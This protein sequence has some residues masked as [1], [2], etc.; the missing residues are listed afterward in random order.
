M[1]ILKK[2]MWWRKTPELDTPAEPDLFDIP[3]VGSEPVKYNRSALERNEW[4]TPYDGGARP[5]RLAKHQMQIFDHKYDAILDA[6]EPS[7][8][9][10]RPYLDVVEEEGL[11]DR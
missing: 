4:G 5:D 9:Q 1:K 7:A 3:S 6:D 2:L 8:A 10:L 11:L